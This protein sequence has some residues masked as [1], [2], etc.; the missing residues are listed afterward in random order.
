[1]AFTMNIQAQLPTAATRTR[2][3]AGRRASAVVR[4]EGE[5][6]AQQAA[7]VYFTNKAGQRVTATDEE[8]RQHG[9]GGTAVGCFRG[10]AH[11]SLW[12]P[13]PHLRRLA[14]CPLACRSTPAAATRR[15]S[16]HPPQEAYKQRSQGC[17]TTALG[18]LG[19]RVG[20]AILLVAVSPG[21]VVV[22]FTRR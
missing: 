3:S 22:A 9:N 6:S 10:R 16:L 18:V 15:V 1:M 2:H 11:N 4:A 17:L 20:L 7:T 12:C 21:I 5:T 8:V 13:R 14:G 19:V